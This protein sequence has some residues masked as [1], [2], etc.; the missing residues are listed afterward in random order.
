MDF[1]VYR[2]PIGTVGVTLPPFPKEQGVWGPGTLG[3]YSPGHLSREN[4]TP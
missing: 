4:D 1:S 2:T 3:S